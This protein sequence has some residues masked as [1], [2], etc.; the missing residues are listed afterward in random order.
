MVRVVEEAVKMPVLDLVVMATG[1][2]LADRI[3][4]W[5]NTYI[6]I[7]V[8]YAKLGAGLVMTWQGYRLHPMVTKFGQGVLIESIGDFIAR[9][10]AGVGGSPSPSPSPQKKVEPTLEQLAEQESLKEVREV[11]L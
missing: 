4:D 7:G 6:G 11:I 3:G 1:V 5:L 2:A 9:A 10:V 8:D